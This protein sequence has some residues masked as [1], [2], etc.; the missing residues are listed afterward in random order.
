MMIDS[1]KKILLAAAGLLLGAVALC[2]QEAP[3]GIKSG[4]L[5]YETQTSGG[6]QYNE[7]W[8]DDYGMLK[9]Q[10]DQIMMEGMGNYH[11]EILFRDG[12]SYTNAWF[13]D[14]KKDEAKMT[15]SIPDFAF[16]NMSE[17]ELKENKIEVL[18]TEEVFGKTCT[19][20]RYKTKSLL[21][22]ITNKVWLWKGIILKMETRG[23]LG[24]NNDM[25]VTEFVENPRLP[26]STFA[27]PA[28][29]K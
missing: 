12:K 23:A 16:Q 7:V 21:R 4:H 13:D 2:A 9:K 28:V 14:E 26:A 10:H 25:M 29:V 11:T 20:Y 6:I 5:K 27:I 19:I 15:E 17:E 24:A 22:T 18:G 3:Y 8:F 1:M